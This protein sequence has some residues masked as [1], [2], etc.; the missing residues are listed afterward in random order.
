MNVVQTSGGFAAN[1]RRADLTVL[2]IVLVLGWIP[3]G[4]Q[5]GRLAWQQQQRH[6]QVDRAPDSQKVTATGWG[7]TD[8]TIGPRAYLPFSFPKKFSRCSSEGDRVEKSA[9][10]TYTI[11]TAVSF[12]HRGKERFR[13]CFLQPPRGGS[14]C[15]A[16][17]EDNGRFCQF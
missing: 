2:C 13:D 17:G 5:S 6:T 15:S 14:C 8:R 16:G 3:N 10:S 7:G 9:V 4:S 11:G 1:C 12:Y